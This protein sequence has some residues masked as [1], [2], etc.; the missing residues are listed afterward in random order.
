VLAGDVAQA[1][2]GERGG[3]DLN[4]LGGAGPAAPALARP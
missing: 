2:L 1:L 4:Q 3:G